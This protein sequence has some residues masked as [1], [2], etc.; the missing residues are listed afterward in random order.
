MFGSLSRPGEPRSRE[1]SIQLFKQ[2]R[3][4]IARSVSDDAIQSFV[5]RLDCFAVA[6]NDA[7]KPHFHIPAARFTPELLM[8]LPPKEGVGNAGCPSAPAASRG[9]N[10]NH[11]SVVTTVAPESSGIPAREWF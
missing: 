3:P 5:I 10:K 8:F 9:K 7:H 4:V 6:R 1:S 2:P 11:T